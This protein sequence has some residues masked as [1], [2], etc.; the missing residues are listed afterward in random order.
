MY[1]SKKATHERYTGMMSTVLK[2]KH[3]TCTIGLDFFLK[4]KAD[5]VLSHWNI[6]EKEK[7]IDDFLN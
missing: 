3:C 1:I 4:P 7:N 2:K 6:I 5:I